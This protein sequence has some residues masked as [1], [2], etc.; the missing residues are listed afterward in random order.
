M[1]KSILQTKH[2]ATLK[3]KYG[4]KVHWL[5]DVLVLEHS[6]PLGGTF[7][8]IPEVDQVQV[9]DMDM[10]KLDELARSRKAAFVRIEIVNPITERQSYLDKSLEG[11]DKAFEDVQPEH[12]RIIDL[13]QSEA[14]ILEQMKPKGRYNIKVAV[15][16]NVKVV[17][18][19]VVTG[20][21]RVS[22]IGH[23]MA[24]WGNS[25]NH[26]SKSITN[27]YNTQK[28][29]VDIFYD[30]YSETVAREKITGRS[31]DY[32][33]DLADILGADDLVRVFI[34]K[35]D[36]VPVAGA[37]ITFYDGVASYL[38]GGSSR[39]RREVMAPYALHWGIMMFAK[40]NGF[41][42]YDLLGVAPEGAGEEHKWSG[43]TRF[44]ENFGGQSVAVIGSYDK[45]Y[46][47]IYYRAYK[48][49]AQIRRKR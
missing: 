22:N 23:E 21:H 14:K 16:H 43:V 4:Q 7:L 38:Y 15:K 42:S 1:Y 17:N 24:F 27:A 25:E 11:F 34:A 8:Y 32:F 35:V 5:S 33:H 40:R 29:P 19:K 39:E 45:I 47:P 9:H 46:R 2:W 18:H 41:R 26:K 30:L 48:R 31:L 13:R 6:L 28:S 49:A 3:S 10:A 37:V 12:R 20:A 44:K 36:D